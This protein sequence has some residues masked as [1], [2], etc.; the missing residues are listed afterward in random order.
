MV[1][2]QIFAEGTAP[3]KH[4][5]LALQEFIDTEVKKMLELGVVWQSHSP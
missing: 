3:V 4:N 2:L 5:T 1:Q